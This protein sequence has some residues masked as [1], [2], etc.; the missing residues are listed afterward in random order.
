MTSK[1]KIVLITGGSRGLGK[2]MALQ[3][4]KKGLDVII[5]YNTKKDEAE[6]VVSEIQTLGRKA[7]ALPLDVS[8]ADTFETFSKAVADILKSVF[9]QDKLD[10]LVNNAGVGVHASYEE[11]TVEQ[12]DS[13]MN[14]HLKA[15]FFL[16]QKLLPVISNGA[17]IVNISSGLARF[18][19]QGYEAYGTM[20]GGVETLTK[21]QA[22]AL[23][24]KG[25]R[26]NV[27]APGAIE[28]D[29]GGG[30]VRDNK[31]LNAQLASLTALGRV[32]LPDDIGGVVAFLCSDDSKWVNGQRIE[33]A[34]GIFL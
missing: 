9:K 6:K 28:T 27:V 10:A 5:T 30:A 18:S 3:T 31:E 21:Y 4:A 29:F 11:T 12:F 7:A 15:P 14:I 2:D 24:V 34:G 25:I 16:T 26:V 13:M 19:F 32:G 33:V 17:S 8:K 1:S 23:G 20:K 22:K